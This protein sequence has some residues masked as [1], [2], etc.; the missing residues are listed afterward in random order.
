MSV[1]FLEYNKRDSDHRG[2]N[3]SLVKCFSK[4]LTK[5]YVGCYTEY[6]ENVFLDLDVN[7]VCKKSQ[8][9]SKGFYQAM[10]H[11]ILSI[12]RFLIFSGCKSQKV[13]ILSAS[14][15]GR[16][17]YSIA[18]AFGFMRRSDIF[19][20]MH[21]EYGVLFD[22]CQSLKRR[23][24]RFILKFSLW[25]CRDKLTHVILSRHIAIH[26]Q[27]L[28]R[29]VLVL[30]HPVETLG[31]VED[32]RVASKVSDSGKSMVISFVGIASEN[33][34]FPQFLTFREKL[35]GEPQFAFQV[36][37]RVLGSYDVDPD[38]FDY[39]SYEYVSHSKMTELLSRTDVAIFFYGC[40]YDYIA[41]GAVI[42]CIKFSIPIIALDS[43]LFRDFSDRYNFVKVFHSIDE[44][45]VF[46][47]SKTAINEFIENSDFSTVQYDF[48][49]AQAVA[50]I[51]SYQE[52][53]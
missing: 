39:F 45:V 21:S 26:R 24:F 13:V 1:L 23:V 40:D 8:G 49:I 18:F 52:G 16:L 19:F 14:P 11:E 35:S 44:M 7:L 34:G 5:A 41:S 22:D 12:F 43:A 9:G 38:A 33:K 48:S 30:D 37:G 27:Y 46:I 36:V 2:I 10:F 29:H 31:D 32:N 42:D 50:R 4:S 47:K 28:G 15:F 51:G 20:V 25:V 53:K 3:R 17:L 6:Y